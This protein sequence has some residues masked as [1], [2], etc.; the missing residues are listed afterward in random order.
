M[1]GALRAFAALVCHALGDLTCKNAIAA[2]VKP[3]HFVGLVL[4]LQRGFLPPRLRRNNPS[5]GLGRGRVA[6]AARSAAGSMRRS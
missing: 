6:A 2:G 1:T 3:H 5:P 4:T